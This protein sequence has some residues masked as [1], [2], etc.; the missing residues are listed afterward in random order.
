MVPN[1]LGLDKEAL[2]QLGIMC[3]RLLDAGRV[4]FLQQHGFACELTVKSHTSYSKWG[5]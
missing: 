1:S 5:H 3:K 2:I 4:A